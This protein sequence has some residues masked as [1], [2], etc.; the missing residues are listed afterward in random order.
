MSTLIVID[1]QKE[2]ITPGRPF[3]LNGIQENLENAKKVLKFCRAKSD[4]SIAHVQHFRQ[5]DDAAIF[6]RHQPEFSGFVEG[7]EPLKGEYYF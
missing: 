3:Y 7:F 1:I 5:E 6:N 4:W 2:Y